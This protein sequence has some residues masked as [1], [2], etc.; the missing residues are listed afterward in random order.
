[1]T[2]NFLGVFHQPIFYEADGSERRGASHRIPAEGRTMSAACPRTNFLARNHR[3]QWY[4]A[5]NSF[6]NAKNIGLDTPMLTRKHL[7]GAP[8]SRLHLVHNQENPVPSAQLF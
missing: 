2:S 8:E 4:T 1:M 6:G 5:G 3:T 7:A